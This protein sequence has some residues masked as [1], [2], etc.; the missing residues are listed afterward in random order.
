MD[1]PVYDVWVLDCMKLED[2]K[3][4]DETLE[5]QKDG[6]ADGSSEAADDE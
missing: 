4:L 6:Q 5:D 1:H 2:T 3:E